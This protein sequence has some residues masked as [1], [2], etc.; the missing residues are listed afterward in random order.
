MAHWETL[1]VESLLNRRDEQTTSGNAGGFAVPL[2]QP[3]RRQMPVSSP[4]YKPVDDHERVETPK[5][6]TK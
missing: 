3:L 6:P 5:K 1:D 4:Q 2:G